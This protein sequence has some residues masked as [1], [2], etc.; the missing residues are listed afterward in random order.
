VVVV[1]KEPGVDVP[2][3]QR[4]LDGGQVHGQTSIVIKAEG[5]ERIAPFELRRR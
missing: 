5:F 4:R 2:F 1:I 3:A